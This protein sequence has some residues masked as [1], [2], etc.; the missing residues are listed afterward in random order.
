MG[1]TSSRRSGCIERLLGEDGLLPISVSHEG[2]LAQ[3]VHSYWD[4]FWALRGLRDAAYLARACGR[5]SAAE[6]MGRRSAAALRHRYSPRSRQPGCSAS[7]TSFP[8]ASSGRTS[9]RRRP[10]T[11]FICSMFLMASTARPSSKHST[12]ISPTGAASATGPCRRRAIPRTRSASSAR[13][14][15][16]EGAMRLWSC[17]VSFCRIAVRRPGISGRRSRG[18]TSKAPAHVGDLP[19][20]WI[21]GRIRARRALPVR[22]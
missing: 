15:G 3:P 12:S 17:C 11:R 4:D 8:A 14:C 9:I 19:H 7:W 2:Y 6:T 21:A 20:T 22:L 13:W 1:A 16:W 10:R 5:E 18:G